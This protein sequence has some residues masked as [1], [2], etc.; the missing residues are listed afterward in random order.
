MRTKLC[1]CCW[2]RVILLFFF[3]DYILL[4]LQ[5][6]AALPRLGLQRLPWVAVVVVLLRTDTPLRTSRLR[7]WLLLSILFTCLGV[8]LGPHGV[9]NFFLSSLLLRRGHLHDR[10]RLQGLAH[11]VRPVSSHRQCQKLFWALVRADFTFF[12]EILSLV[13]SMWRRQDNQAWLKLFFYVELFHLIFVIGF[14]L[15]IHL[16][17]S[18]LRVLIF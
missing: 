8:G 4:I 5:K 1:F 18:L 13:D 14:C 6:K 3:I 12:L 9:L 7:G 11:D 2:I 10:L 15:M 16:R 17:W